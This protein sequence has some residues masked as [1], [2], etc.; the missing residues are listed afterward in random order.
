MEN[1]V[2]RK[3]LVDKNGYQTL[4]IRRTNVPA[5]FFLSVGL[6]QNYAYFPLQSSNGND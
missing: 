3:R 1:L 5:G 4:F 6:C 2:L